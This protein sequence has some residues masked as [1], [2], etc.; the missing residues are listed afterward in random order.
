MM[1]LAL[2]FTHATAHVLWVGAL[3]A[4]AAFAVER[5]LVRS[6]A[7]RHAMH[8]AA[9]L[10]TLLALPVAFRICPV[11]V[12]PSGP[13]V[14]PRGEA[15]T[16][17]APASAQL[18]TTGA[19]LGDLGEVA[20]VESQPTSPVAVQGRSAS[21]ESLAP[22]V[23][24]TYLVGLFGMLLRMACGF[25]GSARMRRQCEPVETGIWS[26]SLRTMGE[27]IGVRVRPALRWSREVAA[28][29]LIGFVKPAILL[30]VALASRLSPAQVEAVLA[31]ELAHLRRRDTCSL[32]VQRVAETVLFFHPAVW[33]MSHRLDA[34]R[35]EACDDLAL[36]AGCDPA[37]YAEALVIC[38]ECRSEH[39]S[40]S[41]RLASRLA[42]T[43]GSRKLLHRRVMRLLGGGDG[44][45]IRLGRT[46]WVL[47]LL[48]VGG[49]A[50]VL[51]AGTAVP[52]VNGLGETAQP[53]L[54]TNAAETAWGKLSNGLQC[55]L[56]PARQTAPPSTGDLLRDISVYV[57]YELRN[58]GSKPVKFL[59]WYCPPDWG[60]S[61]FHVVDQDGNSAPYVGLLAKRFLPTA[62][63]YIT[64]QPGQTL[65]NRVEMQYDFSKPGSYRIAAVKTEPGPTFL[66]Q[67][68][69]GG[70]PSKMAENP[71]NVWIGELESNEVQANIVPGS[72][73]KDEA[74]ANPRPRGGPPAAD[75]A[76]RSPETASGA[77]ARKP[78][79]GAA[80]DGV[81]VRLHSPAP[82]WSQNEFAISFKIDLRS[83]T[84][85]PLPYYGPINAEF[86][87][88]VDGQWY[89][90]KGKF[91]FEDVGPSPGTLREDL[92]ARIAA[93]IW[94]SMSTRETMPR[95]APG[96]HTFRVGFPLSDQPNANGSRPRAV[97]NPVELTILREMLARPSPPR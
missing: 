95:F 24:G 89:E 90:L 66:L 64:I 82:G 52:P 87:L 13:L 3:L 81:Q 54:G 16:A 28:P 15:M 36:A 74:P 44:G 43:G 9:L 68:Y 63:R 61:N 25:A 20:S 69:Y 17:P 72:E 47:G 58:V 27:R 22:W 65:S 26:E 85:R 40:L 5:L 94:R 86:F 56:L 93:P 45:A 78:A 41:A 31:H 38:S 12:D 62:E 14:E 34:S 48:L 39:G 96:R 92:H 71:D 80:T 84:E 67:N 60:S 79:W 33:W 18:A 53:S 32:A 76:V 83:Q 6:A 75:Q 29:V 70:V 73:I 19:R 4:L 46:G 10:L 59:P 35:E 1:Q 30:P 57:T 21:W 49:V 77:D 23:S 42:A 8:L 7:G 97:S 51:A 11:H 91:A 2:R 37:D 55:R 88:E 50:M